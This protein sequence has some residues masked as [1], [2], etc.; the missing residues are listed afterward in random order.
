MVV[1]S[2]AYQSSETAHYAHLLLPAAQ[3]SEK[4]GAMTNSERRRL[5]PSLSPAAW[6][7][8][9][10]LGSVCYVGRQLGF[11][12]QFSYDSAAGVYE[13]FSQLTKGR[14]CDVSGLAINCWPRG[15]PAM[16]LSRTL[17]ADNGCQTAL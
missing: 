13:E 12:R 9:P 3:W 7:K 11:E 16:A 15:V 8:P 17:P 1:V 10:R 6:S 5:L 2:E 4:A 14:L